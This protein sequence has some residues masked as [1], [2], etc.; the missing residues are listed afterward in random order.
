MANTITTDLHTQV[1]TCCV[2]GESA[3]I[4]RKLLRDQHALLEKVD[5]MGAEHRECRDYR[6]HPHMARLSRQFRKGI[7]RE[8]RQAAQQQ[9]RR[10]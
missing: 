4:P 7:Q 3:E 5:N 1:M 2:C 9:L 6:A 10:A 8:E